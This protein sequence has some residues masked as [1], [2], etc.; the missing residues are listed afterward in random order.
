[1]EVQSI[2]IVAKPSEPKA[3]ELA[4]RLIDWLQTKSMDFVVD[5]QIVSDPA[6]SPE[7]NTW[8]SPLPSLP[9]SEFTSRCNPIVVLGGDGTFISV[10]RHPDET[11]KTIIG[12]NMGSLGF[13]TEISSGEVIPILESVLSGNTPL[14]SRY[15]LEATIYRD[16]KKLSSFFAMNDFV[17]TKEALA[18]IFPVKVTI[19]DC[20]AAKIRGDGLIVA[21]P[22]GSTAYSLAAGGS[23]VHPAVQ[24]LLMTPICPHSLTVRP[25]VLPG[26][27]KLSLVIGKEHGRNDSFFLTVDGQEGMEILAGDTIE[28]TTS[29]FTYIVARS[30]GRSYYDI[31]GEKLSWASSGP[32]N[33]NLNSS[34]KSNLK[35][36]E[37]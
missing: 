23:I 29:N 37:S 17:I 14:E 28:I 19:D 2:G 33:S 21:T 36:E 5:D 25:L 16:E 27:S 32:K 12:V 18:R 6:L 15:L 9:R 30:P 10:A 1:M 35:S 4:K 20:P 3:I 13:L 26:D 34:L 31:L 24:A 22:G 11:P 8:T 7:A